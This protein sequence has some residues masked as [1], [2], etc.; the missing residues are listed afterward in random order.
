VQLLGDLVLAAIVHGSLVLGDFRPGRSDVDLLVVVERPLL[1]GEL[2]AIRKAVVA[3]RDSA[4]GGIDVRVVTREAAA[5]PT[6]EPAMELYVGLHG[7]E[8]P[9]ILMRVAEG[10][11]VAEL[12]MVRAD[13]RSLSGAEAARVIGDVPDHWVVAYGDASLARWER[14]TDDAQHAEL[15][16]LTSCRIWRFALEGVHCSKSDA[17]RWALA[18]DPSLAAVK[19]ALGLRAGDPDAVVEPG[20]IATLIERGRGAIRERA[21]AA[22]AT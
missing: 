14:L 21:R 12:S 15:M 2:E 17:G 13:G 4:P 3:R 19:G 8:E 5:F 6:P 18:R 20:D 7:D 16:V 22:G 10:D 11:L 1:D 9:E